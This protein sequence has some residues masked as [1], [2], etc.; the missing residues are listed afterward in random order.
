MKVGSQSPE[1]KSTDEIMNCGGAGCLA[2]QWSRTRLGLIAHGRMRNRSK[3]YTIPSALSAEEH[4]PTITLRRETVKHL[5][6][7]GSR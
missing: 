5:L 4:P 1:T 6:I 3:S 2:S 7:K